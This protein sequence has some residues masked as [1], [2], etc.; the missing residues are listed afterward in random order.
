[1][2]VPLYFS[3]VIKHKKVFHC[4]FMTDLAHHK[5][6]KKKNTERAHEERAFQKQIELKTMMRMRAP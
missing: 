5:K 4:Q 1:M 3:N 6:K 2:Y